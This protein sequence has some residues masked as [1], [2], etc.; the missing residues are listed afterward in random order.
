MLA[1]GSLALLA[2]AVPGTAGAA[3]AAQAGVVSMDP[4]GFTPRVSAGVAV[5]KL[6]KVGSIMFA[7]GDF[8]Q[9]QNANR[10]TTFS[11]NN[12]FSFGA[13][14]GTVTPL[15]ATFDRP[16]VW[17][18]A[19]AGTSLWVGGDFRT[20]N[21]V[22]RR[23]LVK[24]DATTGVV[25][26][27][28]DAHLDGNVADVQLVSGRLIVA[29]KF[30]KRLQALDPATGAD[31]GY[32]NL[33]ITGTVHPNAGPTD[34]YRFAVNPALTRL[35]A[36]GN[37]TAVGGV[38]RSR[39]FMVNLG[40]ASGT[41]ASWYY[42]PMGRAC[43]STKSH[44]QL[45]DVAFSPD[46]GYFVMVATG[47]RPSPGDDGITIC[48]A[49]AR[50]NTTVSNPVRP[51]WINYTGGDT[52]HSVAVTTAAVYIQGHQRWVST[53]GSGCKPGCA[54]REGIAALAPGSGAALAWN[55]GKSRGVGGKDLLVTTSP[56]G[57]WVPSDTNLIGNPQETHEKLAFLPLI[58]GPPETCAGLRAT[59]VGSDG[60]DN[61]IGTP[62]SD[63]IVALA[64]TD[65]IH[66]LGGNDTVCSGSGNDRIWGGSG[67][68]GIWGGS[69]SDR[70]KGRSGNDQLRGGTG[71]DRIWGGSG[72][73]RIWGGAGRD[74]ISGGPGGDTC[75]S[76][77]HAPGCNH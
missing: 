73:D 40:A 70:I 42:A 62:G 76:P 31:T 50:F 13:A 16:A 4:A 33:G 46:G 69:G 54:S 7:G 44:A 18:L 34:V 51:V 67:N 24:L 23:G 30:T 11:R 49:A 15:S 22:A 77:K 29:G 52:L 25:D 55:P 57:L 64:G 9:V 66:G 14:T 21:G 38:T 26:P 60:P 28:F 3:P 75:H 65:V 35:V 43:R 59:M 72:A 20:V 37:F 74:A 1:I 39:A 32:L 68:D 12:L 61:I 2:M 56:A 71:A 17:G 36:I 5:Y 19:S 10:S 58:A 27:A 6:L 8:T 63:V 53:S 47:W 48:D 45:R 41:L